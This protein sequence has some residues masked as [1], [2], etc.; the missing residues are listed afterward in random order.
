MTIREFP[1]RRGHRADR[2][3]PAGPATLPRQPTAA[4]ANR[5]APL[6]RTMAI[7]TMCSGSMRP[8]NAL[9]CAPQLM[10]AEGPPTAQNGGDA[11]RS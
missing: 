2:E 7:L 8:Q 11:C 4:Q 3:V 5:P 9:F 10:N 1:F 6:E